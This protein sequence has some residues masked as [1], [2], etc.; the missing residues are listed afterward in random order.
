MEKAPLS[1]PPRRGARNIPL[2]S[3]G[4]WS[5]I[6]RVLEVIETPKLD[7]WLGSLNTTSQSH[8][9]CASITP[10]SI[11]MSWH[12]PWQSFA[13]LVALDPFSY[14]EDCFWPMPLMLPSRQKAIIR[15]LLRCA[16]RIARAASLHVTFTPADLAVLQNT[17][18]AR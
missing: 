16:C 1:G 2:F 8:S 17:G 6:E 13:V 18:R 7:L 11:L 3:P 10:A 12:H 4:Q 14:M 15:I 5:H 9:C